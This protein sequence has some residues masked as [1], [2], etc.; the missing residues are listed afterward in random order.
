MPSFGE[1]R[2]SDAMEKSGGLAA[3]FAVLVVTLQIM[4]KPD[5]QR[6]AR[7]AG[8]EWLLCDIGNTQSKLHVVRCGAIAELMLVPHGREEW[9]REQLRGRRFEE[10]LVSATGEVSATLAALL[11]EHCARVWHLSCELPLPLA[12]DYRSPH[13]LG[14][15]RIAA[16]AGAVTLGI[17]GEGPVLIADAGTALTL[18]VVSAE[19]RF[20]GGNI[21]PGVR[22]RIE[23]LH[24][25]TAHLP[26]IAS[27][28]DT[29]LIGYSTDTALRAGCVGG[30][31]RE[32]DALADALARDGAPALTVL[33]GGDAELIAPL[34]RHPYRLEHEL[35]AHGMLAILQYQLQKQN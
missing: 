17:A 26:A 22:M 4:G 13:T 28:G 21:S 19:G 32:I 6:C 8:A 30:V 29:P 31:A 1:L 33:T 12:I 15:D 35:V 24:G 16:A 34:L 23:A 18:D 7:A 3:E 27:E 14:A 11:E 9:L 20:L 25:H 10:C 2:P 5:L